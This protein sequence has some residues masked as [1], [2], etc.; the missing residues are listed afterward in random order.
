MKVKVE[1]YIENKS[2]TETLGQ[3]DA[4]II[5]LCL[6]LFCFFETNT[7]RQHKIEIHSLPVCVLEN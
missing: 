1:H 7:Q 2:Q 4:N 5:Y 3:R 6:F